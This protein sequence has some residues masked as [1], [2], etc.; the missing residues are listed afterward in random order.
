MPEQRMRD[1]LLGICEEGH[2]LTGS[3]SKQKIQEMLEDEAVSIQGLKE[4]WADPES[5]LGPFHELP[6]S[7]QN[8]LSEAAFVFGEEYYLLTRPTLHKLVFSNP[9]F[10]LGRT[11]TSLGWRFDT[12][13][14]I[15]RVLKRT[16]RFFMRA[17][18]FTGRSLSK[19]LRSSRFTK[20]PFLFTLWDFLRVDPALLI[21]TYIEGIPI[22]P[23][24]GPVWRST[25]RNAEGCALLGVDL[26]MSG[27][28]V[29]FVEGNVNAGFYRN[30]S[31][32]FPAGDPVCLGFLDYAERKGF[33]RIRFNP[34]DSYDYLFPLE[35]E[36]FWRGSATEAGLQLQIVDDPV[37]GSPY[38]RDS[39]LFM[40]TE[41]ENTLFV[42]GRYVESPLGRMIATKG[43]L[44]DVVRGFSEAAEERVIFSP[45]EIRDD[46]DLPPL[47]ERG[48]FPNIIV[49]HKYVD[50]AR[51]IHLFRVDRIP[52]EVKK[53]YYAVYEYVIPDRVQKAIE[54][55]VREYVFV[56]RAY[57]L[58]TPGGP[59]YCGARKDI[60]E[61][62]VPTE[63]PEGRIGDPMAFIANASINAYS[64]EP[65]AQEDQRCREAILQVGDAID[66]FLKRKHSYLG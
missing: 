6:T 25:E 21:H 16:G 56:F 63:V 57:L 66:D 26:L 27:G 34:A 43:L 17:L 58:V 52:D 44:E 33:E 35:V 23:A 2:L 30:R 14:R 5:S 62:P 45:R 38:P 24:V 55:Q 20:A 19:R 59:V 29:Y 28:K 32:V 54:E 11:I 8:A 65:S 3:E 50:Q 7:A 49:K 39:G 36:E 64:V 53:P 12:E 51:G 47:S 1:L 18:R 41:E 42:N 22:N 31:E 9:I 13:S 40:D 37:N 10:V 61:V 60:S 4:F 15:S 46:R 48:G